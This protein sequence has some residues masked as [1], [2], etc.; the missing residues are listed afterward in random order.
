MLQD[1]IRAGK[2]F[3]QRFAGS[4][5]Q[6]LHRIR[7]LIAL[8]ALETGEVGVDEAIANFQASITDE[9]PATEKI[10]SIAQ[11]IRLLGI[12][13]KQPEN[14]EKLLKQV[15]DTAKNSVVD[16]DVKAAY[17]RAVNAAGDVELWH[18]RRG[19][20]YGYYQR[21]E[22]LRGRFI[23]AQVKA[24]RVGAYPNAIR[25]F[26]A[27]GN[28]GA[29]LQIV[30]RWEDTFATDKVKGQ[31]FYWRGTILAQRKQYKDAARYLARAVVL[32]I[33]AGF[34]TEARWRLA[35]SLEN[36]GRKKEAKV[37]LAR[38]VATGLADNF[39]KMARDKLKREKP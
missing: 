26:L 6:E 4:H 20:A 30:N 31:T 21:V 13:R 27:L 35:Q 22:A 38:L 24:A 39:T 7:R 19:K 16:D 18:G 10:D 5:P 15:E 12:E 29:A 28:Y 25:E 34:E 36:L 37:E 8:C 11:L 32:A 1:A 3:I 14:T 33:G 17:R 9:T 2:R 23:P